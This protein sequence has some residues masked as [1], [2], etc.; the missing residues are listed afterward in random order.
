MCFSGSECISHVCATFPL[1]KC[2]EEELPCGTTN[3]DWGSQDRCGGQAC[4]FSFECMSGMCN[5]DGLCSEV[6]YDYFEAPKPKEDVLVP[7]GAEGDACAFNSDC[8]ESLVCQGGWARKCTMQSFVISPYDENM[9]TAGVVMSVMVFVL[10]LLV[11][12]CYFAARL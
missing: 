8:Q 7:L 12:M 5:S 6:E 9:S 11:C 3:D 1:N 2:V 10:V 4:Q